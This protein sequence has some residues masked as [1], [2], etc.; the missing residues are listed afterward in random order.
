MIKEYLFDVVV[1]GAG[2]AGLSAAAET[3]KAGFSTVIVDRENRPGGILRQCI[4]NGFGVKYFSEELTGPEYAEKVAVIAHEAG[5]ELMAPASV[6]NLKR[7]NDGTFISSVISEAE[8]L[9]HLHSRALILAMGCRERNRGNLATPGDRCAGIY[10]AGAAQRMLNI[11]GRLP[12]RKALIVGSGDIGLIMA[13]RLRWSGIEVAAVV[14]IMPYPAGLNRNIAQCLEDF[15]IPLYLEHEVI[16]ING[17]ERV[18][19]VDIAPRHNG[20][21]DIAQAFNVECD[22]VLFSVGLIPE[23]ELTRQ[24]GARMLPE[25]GGAAVD[26]HLQTTIPGCFAAGNVLHVHDLVDFVSEEA[27]RVGQMAVKYLNG[28]LA[29]SVED[30][31]VKVNA[32]LKYVL[33]INYNHSSGEQEFSFRPLIRGERLVMEVKRRNQTVKKSV[34]AHVCPAEMLK[35]SL[36]EPELGDG[37]ELEFILHASDA[38]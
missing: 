37:G 7:Q 18:S 8:G 4:H 35:I 33:P 11:E 21:A 16:N 31:P 15:D 24:L 17:R 19:S 13:R 25:T 12:G 10:T 14:E 38:Q 27:A 1:I 20:Q 26:Q 22:T 5:A 34:L 2:A 23:N 3:A 28:E 6:I 32:N 29:P 36:N 30:N 9:I